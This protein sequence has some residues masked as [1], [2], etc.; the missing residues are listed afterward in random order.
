MG[1]QCDPMYPSGIRYHH[2]VRVGLF[3][4]GGSELALLASMTVV[5]NRHPD[6]G[7]CVLEHMVLKD[8]RPR[9]V[10]YNQNHKP[11]AWTP[12]RRNLLHFGVLKAHDAAALVEA[13]PH[14][15]VK[16]WTASLFFQPL[17]HTLNPTCRFIPC[18]FFGVPYSDL[19]NLQP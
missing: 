11:F 3:A 6:K 13:V 18:S 19:R 5:R 16:L 7:G 15:P 1:R 2:E 8:P 17:P 10:L 12:M 9:G 4:A 14:I